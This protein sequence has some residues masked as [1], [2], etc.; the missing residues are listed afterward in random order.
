[1]IPRIIH[2][3]W[4]GRNP[5][6]DE[7]ATYVESWK[8]NH[9]GWEH[10]LWTEENIP[11]DLRRPEALERIRH[12]VERADILRYELLWRHGGV[13][14]DTDFE[15]R[16]SME[17]D[18][19]EAEL[20]TAYLKPKNVVKARERV[21]NAFIGALPGHPLLDRA[22]RE[23]RPQEWHG[24]D[25][26]ASGSTFFNELVKEFPDVHILPAELIYPNSPAQEETAIC[27]H[28]YAR[29]WFEAEGFRKAAHRAEKRLYELRGQ[30]EREERAHAK[31][32][33]RLEQAEAARAEPTPAPDK[34]PAGGSRLARLLAR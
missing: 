2:Q 13:Y 9:P 33:R 28:H 1:M 16:R 15:C 22:L 5:L 31:T 20:F 25:R 24:F 17:P 10:R 7:F 11:T 3:I 34:P 32:R 26:S 21:N 18:I 14:V 4:L 27:I 30:L 6:P 8:H 19:G 29:S 12:P 23:L